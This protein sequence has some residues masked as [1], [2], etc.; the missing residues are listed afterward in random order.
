MSSL[1]TF[2]A[3]SSLE[4]NTAQAPNVSFAQY[5]TYAWANSPAPQ[6]P[7]QSLDLQEGSILDQTIRSTTEEKLMEKGLAPAG[8]A[9]PDLFISYGAKTKMGVEYG[10]A[11]TPWGWDD[12]ASYPVREGSITLKISDAHTGNPVWQGT[13]SDIIDR[14][15]PSQKDVASAVSKMLDKYPP[16]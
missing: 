1:L 10:V 12:R 14:A 8:S 2:A 7:G 3:C 6:P 16:A 4:V 13:A 11:T 5:K 9:S 15:G